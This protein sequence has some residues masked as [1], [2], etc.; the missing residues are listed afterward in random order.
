MAKKNDFYH[1]MSCMKLYFS[2]DV[3]N[4]QYCNANHNECNDDDGMLMLLKKK[5]THKK[6]KMKL[7]SEK[8]RLTRN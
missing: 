4:H 5:V 2:L 1:L 3:V 7:T 6:L 8:M